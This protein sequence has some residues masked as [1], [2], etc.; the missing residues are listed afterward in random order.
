MKS[1]YEHVKNSTSTNQT[2]SMHLAM[3]GGADNLHQASG[4]HNDAV[5]HN[6]YQWLG[7]Y[8]GGHPSM[9]LLSSLGL[10]VGYGE[11]KSGYLYKISHLQ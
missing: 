10:V 11:R 5:H 3:H 8:S 2:K 1:K 9:S 4:D 7:W 6:Y